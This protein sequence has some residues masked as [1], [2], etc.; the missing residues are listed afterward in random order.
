MISELNNK[1]LFYKENDTFI[2]Y[3]LRRIRNENELTREIQLSSMI[4]KFYQKVFVK[5][6]K[7]INR[8]IF[9]YNF[10]NYGYIDNYGYYTIH[11]G[12]NG[13]YIVTCYGEDINKAFIN[14]CQSIIDKNAKDEEKQNHREIK[15]IYKNRFG[16]KYQELYF[17]N[18]ALSKWN[19]FYDGNIPSEI[20][21]IY[22]NE[23]A[24][25]NIDSS[26]N[27]NTHELSVNKTLTKKLKK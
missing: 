5:D 24:N 23:L 22:L 19:D 27:T 14:I 2:K 16:K 21:D 10:F 11:D 6:Q 18:Y 20:I 1:D 7:V 8:D 9:D 26:Y 15:K 4:L 13:Y 3:F 17:T 12:E 25:N